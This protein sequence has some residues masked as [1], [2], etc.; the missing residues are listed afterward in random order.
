VVRN[1][2]APLA[3]FRPVTRESYETTFDEDAQ[4]DSS[5]NQC[6]ECYSRVTTNAV[7]TVCKNCGLVIDEQRI[8]HGPE[9]RAFEVDKRERTGVPLT[10]TRH[11]PGLST[12]IGCGTDANGNTLSG[13]KRLPDKP[14]SDDSSDLLRRQLECI[15]KQIGSLRSEI[16]ISRG[17]VNS[18]TS[19]KQFSRASIGR[20]SEC[21]F[22]YYS[23]RPTVR[24]RLKLT[25]ILNQ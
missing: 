13:R 24:R 2:P 10:A 15:A 9:W 16:D 22:S 1:G 12:E 20:R 21:K 8:D 5:A 19:Y 18:S 6:P 4:T 11:D 23:D 25:L 17:D 7:E 3:A 14:R